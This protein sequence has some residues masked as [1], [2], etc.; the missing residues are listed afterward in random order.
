M[1]RALPVRHRARTLAVLALATAAAALAGC[2]DGAARAA[3]CEATEIPDHDA[4][5]V[6][7]EGDAWSGYAP[8]RLENLLQDTDYQL[9]YVDQPCQSERAAD[10][11][12]GRAD[13]ALTSLDQYLIHDPDATVVGVI[14]QSRGADALALGTANHPDLRSLDDIADLVTRFRTDGRKPVLAYTGDSPSETLLNELSNS[15]EQLRLADFELV[16]VDQSATAYDMLERDEAQLAVISEPDTSR[17]QAAGH[18]IALSSADVPGAII[19]VILASDRVIESDRGAVNAVVASFYETMDRY[20][21]D[22]AALARLYAEDAG[23]GVE[24]AGSLLDG[25]VLYGSQEA[26][27]FMNDNVFPLDQ[28]QI[29]QS[30]DSIGS[31]LALVQPDISLDR[32]KVDG[33]YTRAVV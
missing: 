30:I 4:G 23:L 33:T 24:D 9:L 28:P 10:L 29:E 20:L 11:T 31:T 32:A 8:F 13:I 15:F 1:S 5:T 17:A 16:E 2:S 12:S 25:M 21:A 7:V 26:N 27:A 19:D 18:T 3:G 6:V 14:D 22:P